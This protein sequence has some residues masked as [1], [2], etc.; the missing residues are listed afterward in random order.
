MSLPKLASVKEHETTELDFCSKPR[1]RSKAIAEENTL[2][3]VDLC[4]ELGTPGLLKLLS[5][6]KAV[7]ARDLRRFNADP[8][9]EVARFSEG[10]NIS[11]LQRQLFPW[12]REGPWPFGVPMAL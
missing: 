7:F 3:R 10:F 2:Q 8:S 12:L 11:Q 1:I 6:Q 9:L 4:I 5:L